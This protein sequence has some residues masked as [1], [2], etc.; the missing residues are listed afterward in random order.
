MVFQ[1]FATPRNRDK[2][3][4]PEDDDEDDSG[5]AV[6]GE[7]EEGPSAEFAKLSAAYRAFDKQQLVSSPAKLRTILVANPPTR[8][9]AKKVE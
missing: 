9:I 4:V 2:T 1:D 5:A 7:E 3:S 8:R 6:S